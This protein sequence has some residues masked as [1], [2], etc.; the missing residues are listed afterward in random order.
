MD[1]WQA[2]ANTVI[3]VQVPSNVGNLTSWRPLSFSWTLLHGVIFC[4]L[5]WA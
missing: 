2:L 1:I 4:F 5:F 3:K